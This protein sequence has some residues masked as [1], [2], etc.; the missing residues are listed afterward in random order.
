MKTDES[1][2]ESM[3]GLVGEAAIQLDVAA[4]RLKVAHGYSRGLR[5]GAGVVRGAERRRDGSRELFLRGV[6]PGDDPREIQ[7]WLQRFDASR[8]GDWS[9]SQAGDF[10]L[11]A[12]DRDRSSVQ[13]LTDSRGIWRAYV[14]AAN[15]IVTITEE[16][17][18]QILLQENPGLS[19]F[20]VFTYLQLRYPLNPHTLLESTRVVTWGDAISTDG[21][22]LEHRRHYVPVPD[23]PA[24]YGTES[25]CLEALDSAYREYFRALPSHR[26]PLLMLSGGIDSVVLLYYLVETGKSDVEALTFTTE[27][28]R[29][30]EFR[31]A[32]RAARHFGVP[33]H[34]LEIPGSRIGELVRRAWVESD[35]AG[36]HSLAVR[37]WLRSRE[38]PADVIR[39]EDTRI[40]TPPVDAP[41]RLAW[42]LHRRELQDSLPGHLTQAAGGFMKKWPVRRGRNYLRSVAKTLASRQNLQAFVLEAFLRYDWPPEGEQGPLHE[43]LVEETRAAGRRETLDRQFRRIVDLSCRCQHSENAN[44]IRESVRT[45]KARSLVPHLDPTLLQALNRVPLK[46]AM[47]PVFAS[48]NK[49]GSPFPVVRKYVA[50][51]LLDDGVPDSLMYQRKGAP[52]VDDLLHQHIWEKTLR[53]VL[54]RWGDHLVDMLDAEEN[55][56]FVS[57]RRSRLLSVGARAAELGLAAVG[58]RIAYLSILGWRC[59]HS[60]NGA[61][62]T[63]RS[64]EH[65]RLE[66]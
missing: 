36:Y 50:R 40:H 64:L 30:P 6:F 52:G 21:Y 7:G 63:L 44:W 25:E 23:E 41:T 55:A 24:L 28:E 53:P 42:E 43:Q 15:G 45:P 14:H 20:G 26:T 56:T 31:R 17:G 46:L 8:P 51:K 32:R 1:L 3:P 22:S 34:H 39:G 47:K 38:Q 27:G 35:D 29:N 66:R 12:W 59:T 49:T 58:R 11:V 5:A 2:V 62:A 18:D 60:S 4:D 9:R 33:H 10:Y 65:L 37:D 54:A 61:Q 13:C 16:L 57:D 19:P 48:P